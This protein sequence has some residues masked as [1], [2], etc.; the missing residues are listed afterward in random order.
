MQLNSEAV[1][2]LQMAHLEHLLA[3]RAIG[4]AIDTPAQ[5]HTLPFLLRRLRDSHE[6]MLGAIAE[7]APDVIGAMARK[8]D[9]TDHLHATER[10]PT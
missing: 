9:S 1:A 2:R 10:V 4:K 5:R 8:L 7:D 6:A 3:L